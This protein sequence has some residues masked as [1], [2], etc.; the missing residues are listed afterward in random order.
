MATAD[1][2][3]GNPFRAVLAV[4]EALVSSTV[5]EEVLAGVAEIIGMAMS[6]WDVGISSYVSDRDICVFEAWWCEGGSTQED[7]DYIGTVADLRERPDLCRILELPGVHVE[8]ITDGS[9]PAKDREEMDKWGV[10]TSVDTAL[11]VGGE[12]IGLLGLEEKR[13]VRAFTPFELD[14]FD[15]LC[16]LAAIGIHNAMLFRRQQERARHL[17]T[18]TAIGRAFG[19]DSDERSLFDGI[20]RGAAEALGAPRAIIY[21]FDE[22]SDTLTPHAIFQRDYDPAYDTV[23]VPETVEAAL[24]DRRLLIGG[25]PVVEHVSD[26]DLPDESRTTLESWG[27]KTALTVPV[28]FRGRA[29]G[30]LMLIWNDREHQVTPDDLGLTAGI[31]GLAAMALRSARQHPASSASASSRGGVS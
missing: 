23:G 22:T 4:S 7:I 30:V 8:S 15:K 31:A 29:L 6:V 18:L 21:A 25:E 3:R 12:V 17:A 28:V 27:E 26:A 11:R 13:F 10:K 20:A 19:T 9:L 5:Y 2:I 24:G 16:E 1:E 14:L